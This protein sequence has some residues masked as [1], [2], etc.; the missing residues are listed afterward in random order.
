M[1]FAKRVNIRSNLGGFG[2]AGSAS[3][4][5]R[6]PEKPDKK[7][8]LLVIPPIG[9]VESVIDNS[10]GCN[11]SGLAADEICAAAMRIIG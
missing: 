3:D 9:G 5:R 6:V 10:I 11:E 2:V 4:L 1:R 8:I 7:A